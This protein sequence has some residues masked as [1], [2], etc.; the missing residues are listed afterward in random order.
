MG[1]RDVRRKMEKQRKNARR[2]FERQRRINS[3]APEGPHRYIVIIDHLKPTFNIGKIFRSA[4]A[5]GAG[6]IHLVGVDFF[7][8]SPSMGSFKWV[9]A[10]FHKDFDECYRVISK[11]GY[12]IFALDAGGEKKLPGIQLPRKSAFVFGHEEFG[13]SFDPGDYPL[14]E[15]LQIPQLGKVHSLNVSVAA[16][17]VMYEYLRQHNPEYR[18]QGGKDLP[19]PQI[20]EKGR[21]GAQVRGKSSS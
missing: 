6:E 5:F 15:R 4:D 14:I 10:Q 16:S 13:F 20:R 3:Q 7:D 2:R 19:D 11:R 17:V 8:P 12:R 18:C 9:P 1:I 21:T